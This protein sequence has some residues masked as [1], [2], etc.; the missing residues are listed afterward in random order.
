MLRRPVDGSAR[1]LLRIMESENGR[2]GQNILLREYIF[3][4]KVSGPD[5]VLYLLPRAADDGPRGFKVITPR[6]IL[7]GLNKKRATFL[8]SFK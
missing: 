6:Y 7:T 2:G 3:G 5:A 1:A 8:F 4:K